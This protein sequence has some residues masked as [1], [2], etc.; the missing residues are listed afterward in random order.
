M[1]IKLATEWRHAG[2]CPVHAVIYQPLAIRRGVLELVILFCLE[3]FISFRK[4]IP[5]TGA[6][7]FWSQV[8]QGIDEMKR[9]SYSFSFY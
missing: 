2:P 8:T 4:K 3:R 5:L 9:I 1:N 6:P 7:F